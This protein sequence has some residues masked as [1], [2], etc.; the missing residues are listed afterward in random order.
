MAETSD[1]EDALTL[2]D[3][4]QSFLLE[5]MQAGVSEAIIEP[6]GSLG[7]TQNPGL[8][9]DS[10]S[11]IPFYSSGDPIPEFKW[12]NNIYRPYIF[13]DTDY[14]FGKVNISQEI[15]SLKPIDIFETVTNIKLLIE[16]LIIPESLR[17]AHQNGSVFT[18]DIQEIT[19]FIGMNYVMGYHVLPTIR[20]YWSTEPDMGVPY[21]AR[22]MPL[23]RFEEIRRNL[24][25]CDNASQ[26]SPTSSLFD[27][28]YKIRLVMN[29]FNSSFQS[30][31]NNTKTQA[32][33]EH[34]V[35]FKGH[36]IMRQYMQNKPIKRGFKMWCRADSSTGYLFQFDLYTGKKNAGPEIGLGESVVLDLTQAL[37]GL[38]CEIYFDN[39]F[40][41]PMLQYKLAKQNL[42]ACGTVR[43]QRKNNPK[44]LPLDKEM[45]RGDIYATS[46][47]GISF[48]KWMDNK[49]VHLL[50][51]FLSPVPTLK[52]KR[53][54]A[55]SA[56]CLEITCPDIVHKYNKNMGGVDLMDQKKVTYE[57]DRKSKIKYYLRLF[58]DLLDIAMNNSYIVY[59]KLHAQ[60]RIEGH[61]LSSLEYRQVVARAMIGN[62]SIRKH[63]L[64]ST[65]MTKKRIQNIV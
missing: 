55:G 3:E 41:S 21:I 24:H 40:N 36:N 59:E 27:R 4:D 50:T 10:S 32:I 43:T 19:A 49:A 38:G 61:L 52:V 64:P 26:P 53:K 14:E 11:T 12:K 18:T 35:K 22:V 37:V 56:Q 17:Y 44:N 39:F 8:S 57:V 33:D 45:K 62:F 46:F 7:S 63:A 2:D 25:F 31:M 9:S 54:Q 29:H 60:H 1:T 15:Q 6:P 51:N 30:A 34:M 13:S 65:S 47:E 20:S 58:F 5:D 42:K 48:I 16:E 23:S 28:A